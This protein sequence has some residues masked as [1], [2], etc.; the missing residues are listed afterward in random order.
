MAKTKLDNY[1]YHEALDRCY[2]ALTIV[3]SLLLEHPVVK[4]HKKLKKYLVSAIDN[5]GDA[6]QEAS[7]LS[8][9]NEE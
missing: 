3:E 4:K 5:L 6:Y 7:K 2:S 1:H 9:K 8:I